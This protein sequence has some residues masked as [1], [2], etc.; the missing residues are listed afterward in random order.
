[1]NLITPDLGLI[2]WQSIILLVVLWILKKYAWKPI[3]QTIKKR[4]SSI[5]NALNLAKKA[6][7]ETIQ[8]QANHI[9]MIEEV[10]QECD[11]MMKEAKEAEKDIIEKAKGEA[12]KVT[13]AM[14]EKARTTIYNEKKEAISALKK[15]VGLLAIQIAEQLLRRELTT[16]KAQETFVSNAV[17]KMEL[18]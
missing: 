15:Q 6:R 12:E 5:E 11:Q 10:R 2:F 9:K 13:T 17:T 7:E 18:N 16:K 8:L 3:L 1:M 14:I 4:E